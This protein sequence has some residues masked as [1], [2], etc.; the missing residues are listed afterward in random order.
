M[1]VTEHFDFFFEHWLAGWSTDPSQWP[2][3]SRRMFREWFSVRSHTMVEDVVD[4]P[5]E[6]D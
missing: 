6:I 5:Y 2:Q 1:F 4:A 3:R